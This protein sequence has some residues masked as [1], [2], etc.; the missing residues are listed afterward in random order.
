MRRKSCRLFGLIMIIML[1]CACGNDMPTDSGLSGAAA[2]DLPEDGGWVSGKYLKA[3]QADLI[4]T[5]NGEPIELHTAAETISFEGISDGDEIRVYM[6]AVM[7][8]WPAQADVY[9]VEK[10]SDGDIA[11]IPS[12]LLEQLTEFG[13]LEG[14]EADGT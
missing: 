13:W 4:I 10:L 12:K 8:T 1:F 6:G 7:E 2:S 5:E 3:K 9:A 11:D 14:A